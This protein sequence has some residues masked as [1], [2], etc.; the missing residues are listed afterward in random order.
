MRLEPREKP[1]N[2]QQEPAYPNHETVVFCLCAPDMTA[3]NTAAE[4]QIEHPHQ[5]SEC[6]LFGASNE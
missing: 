3:H 2:C 5:I 1:R 6:G 4:C